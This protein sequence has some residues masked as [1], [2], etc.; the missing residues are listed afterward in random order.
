MAKDIDLRIVASGG[1]AGRKRGGA[2]VLVVGAAFGILAA[3]LVPLC[4]VLGGPEARAE[5]PA[6]VN[7]VADARFSVEVTGQGPDIVLIPG[8]ASPRSVWADL[9]EALKP[10]YRLHVLQIGGFAG[11]P[12]GANGQGA[13]LGPV[14]DA[15]AAYIAANKLNAPIVIG[16]SL[17]GEVALSLAAHYP[18]TVGKTMIVDALPFA[19][20]LIDPFGTPESIA[21]RAKAFRDQA[22]AASPEQ[23]E[24]AEAQAIARLVKTEAARAPL[25]AASVKSDRT[26]V[27]NATYELMTTDL[28]PELTAIKTP[29]EVLYAYDPLYG[30]PSALIDAIYRNAYANLPAARFMRVDSSFH[31]I[32]IDQKAAFFDAVSH[33]LA[34]P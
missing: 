32:M 2:L 28:R 18:G 23:A 24:A 4:V 22:L 17:G 3:S 21:A 12:A 10:H 9:V 7:A 31:F 1:P 20:L 27:A 16:H 11:E 13:F 26:A 19:G 6:K 33:F 34:E 25:V 8:L 29:I 5:A 30:I 15:I 14:T